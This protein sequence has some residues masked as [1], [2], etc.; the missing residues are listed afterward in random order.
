[1]PRLVQK[2]GCAGTGTELY[3]AQESG[4]ERKFG[5]GTPNN[6]DR[7]G[8][9]RNASKCG[10]ERNGTVYRKFVARSSQGR[11]NFVATSSSLCGSAFSAGLGLFGLPRLGSASLAL[12]APAATAAALRAA[13]PPK[14]AGL[15][16][17]DAGKASEADLRRGKPSKARPGAFHIFFYLAYLVPGPFIWLMAWGLPRYFLS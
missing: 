3:L 11:R 12:P 13:Q 2:Q 17:R 5:T 7:N 6:P 9:D 15:L 10:P 14:A 4:P 8:S 1:M 16:L